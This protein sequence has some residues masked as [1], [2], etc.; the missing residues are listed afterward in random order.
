MISN[1]PQT[2]TGGEGVNNNDQGNQTTENDSNAGSNNGNN[3]RGNR[4][5]DNRRNPYN[6]NERTWE[7]DKGEIG[8]VLG[9]RTEYLDKKAS[10]RIFIEKLI[11]YVLREIRDASDVLPVLSK[12]ED[13][14]PIFQTNNMPAELSTEDK[15]KGVMVAIQQQ[16][17]KNLWIEKLQ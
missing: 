6:A 10:F 11:E 14:I 13:P 1:E 16:R 3:S 12:R 17:V 9:L 8:A 4:G 2:R 15:K 5:V 7:G